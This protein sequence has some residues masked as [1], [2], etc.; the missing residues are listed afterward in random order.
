MRQE[1]RSLVVS[2]EPKRAALRPS[3]PS[4]LRR[5]GEALSRFEAARAYSRLRDAQRRRPA[6]IVDKIA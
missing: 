2:M 6:L 3:P 1:S 5:S 4:S